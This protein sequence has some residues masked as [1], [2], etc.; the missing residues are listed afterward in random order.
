M[1]VTFLGEVIMVR[2]PSAAKRERTDMARGYSLHL[3]LNSVDPNHYGGW[4]G[5]LNACENDA[6]DMAAIAKALGYA[7]TI[8]LLTRDATSTRFISEMLK[9][10]KTL[11]A[12]DIL[13]LSY[14]GHGG[15][16]PDEAGDEDDK[17]DETWCL[18]DRQLIDDEIY[19]V[20]GRF[21]AGVRIVALSDSCHSG[22]VTRMR[23]EAGGPSS[24]ELARH[25]ARSAAATAPGQDDFET[26][27]RGRAAPIEVTMDAYNEHK[28]L[29]LSLQIASANA[30]KTVS[31][32]GVILISGCMD[33]Q[34]SLDGSKNGLFT[35]NL[36]KVWSNGAFAGGYRLFHKTIVSRMPPSQ[37]PNLFKVGNVTP[38]FINQKPFV[39]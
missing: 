3:G 20:L 11:K 19:R 23:R 16:I 30:E 14:S 10:T 26:E 22:T 15:Q 34:L 9:L 31:K 4:D 5:E 13:F 38:D 28:D 36:K 1:S 24:E 17:M 6:K 27:V 29:Y 2:K 35:S 25:I 33:D 12:G 32:A 21:E 39:F 7:Q 37:T 8:L 18:F